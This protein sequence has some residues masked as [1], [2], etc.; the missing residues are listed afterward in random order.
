MDLHAAKIL[1]M[2]YCAA[3]GCKHDSV[4]YRELSCFPI[5]AG[6][7]DSSEAMNSQ[8]WAAG[9]KPTGYARL[10]SAYFE[11]SCFVLK[12]IYFH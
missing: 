2:L 1:T 9:W 11:E 4:R 10:C 12:L 5:S 3:F 7:T 6:K 8:L